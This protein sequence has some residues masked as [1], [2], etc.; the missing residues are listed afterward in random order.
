MHK[1]LI[2]IWYIPSTALHFAAETS[3]LCF[4]SSSVESHGAVPES[5]EYEKIKNYALI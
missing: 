4:N 5:D 1:L 3:F 2:G